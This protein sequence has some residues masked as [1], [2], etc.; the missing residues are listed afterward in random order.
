MQACKSARVVLMKELIDFLEVD[1][2]W[3][4]SALDVL[5]L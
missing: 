4:E 1:N 2:D 5:R 3:R